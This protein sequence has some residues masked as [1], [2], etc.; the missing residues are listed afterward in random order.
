[1]NNE[2]LINNYIDL[3]NQLKHS[4]IYDEKVNEDE[5]KVN[6]DY[7]SDHGNTYYKIFMYDTYDIL[8]KSIRILHHNFYIDS[9][10][11]YKYI[12][13]YRNGN[14]FKY[15]SNNHYPIDMTRAELITNESLFK[16]IKNKLNNQQK[17]LLIKYFLIND[18]HIDDELNII[19]N[20]IR[21]FNSLKI[22]DFIT[23]QI[24]TLMEYVFEMDNKH[25]IN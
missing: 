5:K 16:I 9:I 7:N 12:L 22:D 20:H 1:M 17:A 3:L 15:N 21:I 4:D 11:Y 19:R 24:K 8:I 13:F 14:W 2:E 10:P 6:D 23:S 18:Y 25:F